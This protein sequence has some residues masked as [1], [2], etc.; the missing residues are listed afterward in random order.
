MSL[1]FPVLLLHKILEAYEQQLPVIFGLA[2]LF[3]VLTIFKS[4]ASDPNKVWWRNRGLATDI[5][6]ALIHGI[7]GPYFK[8]PALVLVYVILSHTVMRPEDVADFFKNGGGP[9]STLPFWAQVVVQL[10]LADF[11]L[12]WIHRIFHGNTMWRYHAIH[13]SSEEV[14]WTSSYRFH[15]INLIMQPALVTIIMLTLGISPAV[16]AFLVPFD[17]LTAAWVHANLN[18]TFGPL[19]YVIATPV[20]HRWHHTLPDEGGNSNFAPTFAFWDWIFG[21]FYMPEGKLPQTFGCDDHLFPEGYFQQL[22]YPFK[23]K[24]SGITAIEPAE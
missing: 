1:D 22:L 16:M 19:K 24:E 23:P 11:L 2:C 21:T 13:H 17:V 12:Y 18:W 6:Y 9:L 7:V 8:L 4:Q 15:P 20:F 10:V 5:S 14:D 3:A